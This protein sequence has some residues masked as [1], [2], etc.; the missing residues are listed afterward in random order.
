MQVLKIHSLVVIVAVGWLWPLA[1]AARAEAGGKTSRIHFTDVTAETGTAGLKETGAHGAYWCDVDG[2]GRLDLYVTN[3][4]DEPSQAYNLLYMN[5]GQGQFVEEARARGIEHHHLPGS[6][7][8]VF[9]DLDNDGD[10]DVFV[11]TTCPERPYPATITYD[12]IYRNDGKGHFT[13]ITNGIPMDQHTATRQVLAGDIDGDGDLDLYATN[14]LADA[15]PF[16]K[17]FDPP[18]QLK[19]FFINDGHARF[20]VAARGVLFSGFTQ[21]AT[22]ADLDGDG[23][24]DLAEAKWAPPSTFYTNDGKGQFTDVGTTRGL[25]TNRRPDNGISFG[26]IDNDGDLDMVV[27]R[28]QGLKAS[29]LDIY[30][31]DGHGQFTRIAELKGAGGFMAS[32]GDFDHDGDLDIYHSGGNIYEN[33]GHGGFTVLPE[34][35]TG[36]STQA[37]GFRDP[38]G[39]AL[40]DFDND[41]DLD[42]FVADKH[43]SCRLLRNDLNDSNYLKLKLT[44]CR[45]EAGALGAKV[46][47]YDAG[48]L[49]DKAHLRGYREVTG[50]YGYCA[51]DSP[52]VHFGLPAGQRFD[53][54][55]RYLTGE[56][57]ALLG[58]PTTQTVEIVGPQPRAPAGT[59]STP[60]S[61][62]SE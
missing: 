57:A 56:Q 45:G 5:K 62:P 12:N 54:R 59:S 42:I 38:R 60:L 6:H 15:K 13:D 35:Q 30:R 1:D 2:D 9:C 37:N 18:L 53:L 29:W 19:N 52:I 47:V 4:G 23:D 36:L 3:I 39:S 51:Q 50:A 24:L 27:V 16:G 32:L 10:F 14:Q 31:N 44:S 58:V 11:S 26:D 40:G 55:V 28:N 49:G 61:A 46:E 17:A 8:T 21:G 41:G 34:S 22:F 7:G 43:S 33:D 20:T 25:P 48:H